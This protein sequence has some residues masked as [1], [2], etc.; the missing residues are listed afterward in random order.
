MVS[1]DSGIYV[2]VLKIILPSGGSNL[3]D[4]LQVGSITGIVLLL[5]RTT[6]RII[7]SSFFF[8]Q[9]GKAKAQENRSN[10]HSHLVIS[11]RIGLEQERNL[12]PG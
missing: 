5:L 7:E 1:S 9:V 12:L 8:F 11:G 10:A 6:E 2:G 4:R 3:G